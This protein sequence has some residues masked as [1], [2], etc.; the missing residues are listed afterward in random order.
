[1]KVLLEKL[2]KPLFSKNKDN[3]IYE[4]I[5]LIEILKTQVLRLYHA[6]S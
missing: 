4:V 6:K 1:M 5:N 3:L 2:L